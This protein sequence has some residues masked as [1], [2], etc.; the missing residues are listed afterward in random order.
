MTLLDADNYT[1]LETITVSELTYSFFKC[2]QTSDNGIHITGEKT[3][4]VGILGEIST[5][6]PAIILVCTYMISLLFVTEKLRVEKNSKMGMRG[7]MALK[8]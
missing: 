8:F 4:F 1:V 7:N 3:D 5:P 6:N 2:K